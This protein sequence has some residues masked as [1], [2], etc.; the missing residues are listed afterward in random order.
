MIYRYDYF[1]YSYI[2]LYILI[3]H[4]INTLK[5]AVNCCGCVGCDDFIG[6]F[7]YTTTHSTAETAGAVVPTAAVTAAARAAESV[8]AWP[9]IVRG[10]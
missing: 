8:T 3:N 9:G 1:S 6:L 4:Y 7:S 10:G 5:F 2:Q